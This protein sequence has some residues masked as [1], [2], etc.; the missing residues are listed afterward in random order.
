MDKNFIK[1]P[2]VSTN[3]V[4]I[5]HNKWKTALI[6]FGV[7]L[8]FALGFSLNYLWLNRQIIDPADTNWFNSSISSLNKI[9]SQNIT[10]S[11][12]GFLTLQLTKPEE[13]ESFS[14]AKFANQDQILS[15]YDMEDTNILFLKQLFPDTAN[16]PKTQ[17]KI[18]YFEAGTRQ[19]KL[20]ETNWLGSESFKIQNV[21]EYK[22]KY[23]V[24]LE[25]NRIIISEPFFANPKSVVILDKTKSFGSGEK[26]LVVSSIESVVQEKV[27]LNLVAP[28]SVDISIKNEGNQSLNSMSHS[29]DDTKNQGLGL[30]VQC[31]TFD[32]NGSYEVVV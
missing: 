19:V 28:S 30:L 24:I 20:L 6:Y 7:L 11:I 21:Q 23:W 14:I 32:V 1:K 27:C 9:S 29:A 12:D 25:S 26:E 31:Y 22:E 4:R 2:K 3:S 5:Y 16:L 13:I 10:N 18:F 15:V 8:A 17:Q